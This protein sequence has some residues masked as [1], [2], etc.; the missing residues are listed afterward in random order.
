M[1]ISRVKRSKRAAKKAYDRLSG[2]YDLLAGSSEAQYTYLGLDML[3]VNTG[4]NILEIGSGT[5]KALVELCHQAGDTGK[6]HA[7]DIS[8]GML[9][10][11]HHRLVG[12]GL[13]NQASLLEGDGAKLPYKSGSFNAIFISFTLELF[14]TPEIPLVLAECRRVLVP[15]GRLGVVAMLKTGQPGTVVRLYEWFHDK[16]PAYVDCRPI[17]AQKIL[18]EA[19]FL[20][21]KD[22]M[23]NMWGLP[24]AVVLALKK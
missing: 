22:Q 4:E 10:T 23:K 9:Q 1:Q 16:L 7:I 15:T 11:S 14:D 5:G 17:D 3:A 2:V 8:R 20:I 12:T 13:E 19:G 24:V 18:K 21:E 6:V